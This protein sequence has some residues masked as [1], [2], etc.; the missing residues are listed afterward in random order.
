MSSLSDV[1]AMTCKKGEVWSSR[2]LL[3]LLVLEVAGFLAI[4]LR[5]I[6]YEYDFDMYE[7]IIFEPARRIASG[8]P[9]YG[10]NVALNEPFLYSCYGPVYYLIVGAG[11]NLFGPSFLPGRS[12]SLCATIAT[13]LVIYRILRRRVDAHSAVI[14]ALVFL[15]LPTSWT[16]GTLQRVDAFA[17]F[18]SSLSFLLAVDGTRRPMLLAAGAIATVTFFCKASSVSVGVSAMLWYLADKR[19]R[20]ACLFIL[21]AGAVAAILL[22]WLEAT[23]NSGYWWNLQATNSVPFSRQLATTHLR[24]WF[25]LPLV[26]ALVALTACLALPGSESG[27]EGSAKP[28]LLFALVSG[29]VAILTCFRVGSSLNYFQEFGM[30]LCL[31]SGLALGSFHAKQGES[32]QF[33]LVLLSVAL[34]LDFGLQKTAYIRGRFLI[35]EAKK[36]IHARLVQDLRKIGSA[37]GG[38]AGEY[39]QATLLAGMEVFFNDLGIYESGPEP[40]RRLWSDWLSSNRLAAFIFNG[41]GHYAGYRLCPGYGYSDKNSTVGASGGP[42]LYVR[43]DLWPKVVSSK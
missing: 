28:F 17:V 22:I 6:F 20:D 26:S 39:N 19:Y 7:G 23:G 15:T 14:A 3:A 11:A 41:D 24:S 43:E 25:G 1:P 13:A 37:N 40:M 10:P 42:F 31:V 12:L 35:P 4:G 16:F 36:E 8:Q 9:I 33:V 29:C 38:V 27:R 32:A 21:G 18:M 30:A 2:V 5:S 34:V